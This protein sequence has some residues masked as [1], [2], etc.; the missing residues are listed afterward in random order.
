MIYLLCGRKQADIDA[1]RLGIRLIVADGSK[2]SLSGKAMRIRIATFI[3]ST[4]PDHDPRGDF[5]SF[6]DLLKQ[7]TKQDSVTVLVSLIRPFEL[8]PLLDASP[9]NLVAILVLAF[10]EVRWLF[11]TIRGY[12]EVQGIHGDERQ[13]RERKNQRLHEFRKAH[14]LHNLFCHPGSALFDG[15]GLRD[16]IRA[17]ML[18]DPNTAHDAAYLPRRMQNAVAFDEESDYAHLHAYA[19]Y[20]FGFRT[21]A[22]TTKAQADCVLGE[23]RRS[24]PLEVVFEDL[25]LN[26]PDGPRGYSDLARRDESE[27]KHSR[28]KDFPRLEM[29]EHRIFVTSG[30]RTQNDEEKQAAN[31][32][33]LETQRGLGKHIIQLNK[34]H[35]GIF[36]LWELA[37]LNRRLK[38]MNQ[39]TGRIYRG[40]GEGFVWPPAWKDLDRASEEKARTS[41]GGGHSAPGILLVIAKSLIDRAERM[42]GDVHTIEEAVLGAVLATDALELL[43]GK[44]PTLSIAALT[45]KHQF[46]VM[47]ELQFAGV[48]YHFPVKGRIKE[49]EKEVQSICRWFAPAQQKNAA[50]NAEMSVLNVLVCTFREFNQFDEEQICMNRVRHLHNTLWMRTTGWGWALWPAMRYFEVLLAS[51]P[52]FCLALLGWILALSISFAEAKPVIESSGPSSSKELGTH[53]YGMALSTFLGSNSISSDHP[54]WLFLT[55]VAVVAG[56]AHLGIFISHLYAIISRK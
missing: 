13:P 15:S 11:G 32:T 46:E 26:L 43:G 28:H 27:G 29:A 14:G 53:P 5:H 47:A 25:F 8:N 50:L 42:V 7:L 51:F 44:T 2:A 20:R 48:E 35:G 12:Q 49:I 54:L 3:P 38:W 39:E 56:L 6:H 23:S 18:D 37:K 36:S 9:E 41:D 30:Q 45:L 16:W 4:D 40:V 22:L 10:P 21:H 55:S 19:A 33:Y 52:K 17:R 31:R 34:P 1:L 24:D